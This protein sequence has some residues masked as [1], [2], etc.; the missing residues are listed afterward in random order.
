MLDV[1]AF[2]IYLF[3]LHKLMHCIYS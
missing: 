3:N 2:I 1:E